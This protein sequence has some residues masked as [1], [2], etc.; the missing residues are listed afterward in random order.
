MPPFG[1]QEA[2]ILTRAGQLCRGCS[3]HAISRNQIRCAKPV[4][5]SGK[6]LAIGSPSLESFTARSLPRTG[7][8]LQNQ[9]LTDEAKTIEKKKL[10]DSLP[11]RVDTANFQYPRRYQIIASQKWNNPR[12]MQFR[13]YNDNRK[14]F[15]AL[16]D[17]CG[18]DILKFM[19]AM[20]RI[21]RRHHH[22]LKYLRQV[23]GES[24]ETD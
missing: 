11:A 24:T 19:K 22:P 8:A 10:Y 5:R 18:G 4:S 23:Y 12:L 16:L 1:C 13:T 20:N 15:D 9:E 2:S 6:S 21:A 3:G 17:E 7:A 14:Y